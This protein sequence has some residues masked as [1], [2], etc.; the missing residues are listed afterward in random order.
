V[1][2]LL[3]DG[4]TYWDESSKG[5]GVWVL[6]LNTM[7]AKKVLDEASLTSTLVGWSPESATLL[8]YHRTDAKDTYFY[9]IKADG[10]DRRTLALGEGA[11]VLGWMNAAEGVATNKVV[12]DPWPGRFQAAGKDGAAVAQVMAQYV[13]T[14][15]NADEKA[16]SQQVQQNLTQAGWKFDGAG[17][18]VRRISEGAFVAYLPPMALYVLEGGRAT[19]VAS[20]QVVFE[21][22]LEGSDLGLIYGVQSGGGTQPAYMLL[23]RQ[24][25]GSWKTL[26]T[27]Q[28]QRDWVTT[29]GLI[30]FTEKGLRGV[31]IAGTSF[32][33]DSGAE[34]VFSECRSCLHR[35][36][37]ATWV[38]EGDRYVRQ[39]KLAANAPLEQALWEMT[40][41]KPYAV[42]YEC[43]RRAR[44]GQNAQELAKDAAVLARLTELGLAD[45]AVRL[46]AESEA[47]DT[48]LF[49]NAA[50]QARYRATVQGGKVVGIEAV[51]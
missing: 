22:R 2:Y 17:P 21:A 31:Q 51:K 5:L 16:L 8:G 20:G 37:S 27:P 47:K 15:A 18:S 42:L 39:T 44:K 29:D 3:R 34:E 7:Q 26:W 23:R 13:A 14:Q 35:S 36:L 46:I 50:N 43:L 49:R 9:T 11:A 6:D 41:Q 19:A 28:G 4:K 30:R 12:V 33:L 25:D 45:K 1:A 10:S 32:G 40:E 24:A 38:R 48:V